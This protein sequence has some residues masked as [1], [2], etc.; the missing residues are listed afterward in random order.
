MSLSLA[1]NQV[2]LPSWW[3][4]PLPQGTSNR[5]KLYENGQRR[6]AILESIASSTKP[7]RVE[8]LAE[9]H[10]C[11]IASI[12]NFVAQLVNEGLIIRGADSDG[13]ITVEKCSNAR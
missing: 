8:S 9:E 4:V 7:V 10:D 1:I 11:S 6:A 13:K 12:R 3:G 5:K 2:M